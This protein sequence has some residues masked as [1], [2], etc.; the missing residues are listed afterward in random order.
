MNRNEQAN[1]NTQFA[2]LV[3]L[4]LL[5]NGRYNLHDDFPSLITTCSETTFTLRGETEEE[6]GG[7]IKASMVRRSHYC[8]SPHLVCKDQ[9]LKKAFRLQPCCKKSI[10]A[11]YHGVR[12]SPCRTM[13]MVKE[14][15]E[16]VKFLLD[17]ECRHLPERVTLFPGG[18]AKMCPRSAMAW[19]VVSL[20][21]P[22][23]HKRRPA[24]LI[25]M[26]SLFDW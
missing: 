14:Q 2:G 26:C 4:S 11:L 20:K 6:M 21:E 19:V 1:I 22:C 8:T 15:R 13:S 3:Q 9:H 17:F 12:R 5:F 24:P 7:F 23:S 10:M 16:D 18:W 25:F